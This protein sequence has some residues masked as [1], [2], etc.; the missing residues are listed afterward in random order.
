MMPAELGLMTLGLSVEVDG[1]LSVRAVARH[2]AQDLG[3]IHFPLERVGGRAHLGEH[4]REHHLPQVPDD[5]VSELATIVAPAFSDPHQPL[6]LVLDPSTPHAALVPWERGLGHMLERPVL[7]L[8]Q[9]LVPEVP[10]RTVERVAI[11]ASAPDGEADFRSLRAL[12]DSLRTLMPFAEIHLFAHERWNLVVGQL[13]ATVFHQLL[14]SSGGDRIRADNVSPS[15]GRVLETLGEGGAD[16][17]HFIGKGSFDRDR[18]S[19]A[20]DLTPPSPS[21]EDAV[22]YLS[23]A[24]LAAFLSRV[25]ATIVGFS[26]S[27][28]EVWGLGLRLLAAEL[29]R[30]RPGPILLQESTHD[31]RQALTD[32][33]AFL[34]GLRDPPRHDALSFSVHPSWLEHG[35][36]TPAMRA[37]LT[38]AIL[39]SSDLAIEADRGVMSPVAAGRRGLSRQNQKVVQRLD[40]EQSKLGAKRRELTAYEAGALEALAELRAAMRDGEEP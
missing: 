20:F 35:G 34:L 19:F 1:G 3:E 24:T 26:A 23:S 14:P 10:D 32:G 39:S 21:R 28:E 31:P 2:G 8:P 37:A 9:V 6:W 17:V 11:C 25:G 30:R 27:G 33:Y 36:F 22:E 4:L 40:W 5:L 29:G 12:L 16:L 38:G 18:A 15:L 7:R 13:G